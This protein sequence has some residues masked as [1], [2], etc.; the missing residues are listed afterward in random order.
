MARSTHSTYYPTTLK[1]S[2]EV[3]EH[4]SN[5]K[6]Y[7]YD[8]LDRSGSRKSFRGIAKE[9]APSL[10]TAHRWK[11]E[12]ILLGSPAYKRTRK[13]SKRL[14][15]PTKVSKEVFQYLWIQPETRSE[16]NS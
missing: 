7:L 8:A 12:R 11:E 3:H 2:K 13:L 14:S 9:Y 6:L 1:R 5:S 15:T 10:S 16:K 4:S